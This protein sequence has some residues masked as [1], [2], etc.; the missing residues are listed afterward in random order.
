MNLI[1]NISLMSAIGN[2]TNPAPKEIKNK[3]IQLTFSPVWLSW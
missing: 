1:L 3:L 2:R